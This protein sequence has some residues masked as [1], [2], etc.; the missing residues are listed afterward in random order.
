MIPGVLEL[1]IAAKT[2]VKKEPA[3]DAGAPG[4]RRAA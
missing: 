3:F 4:A 2:A 1:K